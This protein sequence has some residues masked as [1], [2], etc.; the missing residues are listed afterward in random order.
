MK[1]F[2]DTN[3]ILE[4]LFKRKEAEAIRNIFHY[5]DQRKIEKFVSA[6]SFYTVTYLIDNHLK[7]EGFE[8]GMRIETL[9]RILSTLFLEYTIVGALDWKAG[10]ED[11]A[12]DD[13][14]DSY[15]YQA[16]LYAKCDVLIT[17]NAK[18][19]KYA[20]SK[21]LQTCTPTDFVTT[22]LK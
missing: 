10:I 2:C 18:D 6:G 14:E 12:F 15:Q 22:Y 4:F 9:R 1:V 7:K 16:A 3:I 19:F 20:K 8:K 21:K 13:I 17:L 5:L 11:P